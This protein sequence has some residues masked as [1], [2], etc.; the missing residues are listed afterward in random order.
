MA[1][2]GL[3]GAGTSTTSSEGAGVPT[4]SITET[5]GEGTNSGTASSGDVILVSDTGAALTR[6]LDL[7]STRGEERRSTR[8]G[9]LWVGE[10]ASTLIGGKWEGGG[11]G[12][13]W[14]EPG[15]ERCA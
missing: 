5:S 11:R 14:S 9:V 2:G 1:T 6:P 15:D 8:G 7:R 4:T 10:E 12:D 13:R 3:A